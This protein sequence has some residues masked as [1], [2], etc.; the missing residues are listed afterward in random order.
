[1]ALIPTKNPPA[2]IGY[3]LGIFAL[4]PCVGLLLG[5]AAIICGVIGMRRAKRNPAIEGVGHAVTAIVLGSVTTV[6]WAAGV[7]F[8]LLPFGD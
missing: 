8:V 7:V 4:I 6:A 5:P 1:M 2:L 3:Y